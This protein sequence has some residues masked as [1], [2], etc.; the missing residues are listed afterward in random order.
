MYFKDKSF[1][2]PTWWYW[3]FGDGTA[4]ML[5]NPDH[6]YSHVGKYSITLRVANVHGENTSSEVI[7][8]RPDKNTTL[9]FFR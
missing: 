5:Q 4:S 1:G 6:V 8:A 7:I 9:P 3:D 2:E